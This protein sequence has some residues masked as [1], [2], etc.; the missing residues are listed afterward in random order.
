MEKTQFSNIMVMKSTLKTII[1]HYLLS[2]TSNDE[3]LILIFVFEYLT[4]S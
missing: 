3:D 4:Q 2:H 1:S